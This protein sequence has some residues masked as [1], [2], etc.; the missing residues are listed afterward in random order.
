[1]KTF[2]L[3]VSTPDGTVFEGQASGLS[4]RGLQG[5]LAILPGHI[6]LVT[7]LKPCDAVIT[8]PDGKE[9]RGHVEG[10]ILTVGEEKTILL[11]GSV[12]WA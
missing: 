2:E 11:T 3:S 1:M 9:K 4:V 8:L 6:P 7:A 12:N 10:G 5:D